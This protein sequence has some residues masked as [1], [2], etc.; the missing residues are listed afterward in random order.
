MADDS[1]YVADGVPELGTNRLKVGGLK[2][3][4]LF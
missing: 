1:V 3:S 2:T 4:H